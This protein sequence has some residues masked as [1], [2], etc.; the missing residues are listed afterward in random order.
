M[1]RDFDILIV[2]AGVLG[3]TIAYWLSTLTRC[4]IAIIEKESM[5]AQ[6]TSSRNTG[7]VHR[8]FYLNPTK[9]KVFARASQKSYF[10]WKVL[11]E[12]YK[13]P[14]SK[15]GTLEVA[16]EDG[17]LTTLAQYLKW[18]AL[19]GMDENEVEILDPSEVSRIEPQVRCLGG[20]SLQD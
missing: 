19:N 5:V 14:W 13:L 7:V 3:V 20:D 8:P 10:L 17:Q 18:A 4:S 2:G 16:L 1:K 12:A 15:V 6:H 9:K 11:A